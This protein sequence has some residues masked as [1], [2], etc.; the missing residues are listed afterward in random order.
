MNNVNISSPIKPY[1]PGLDSLRGLAII[2]V[3]GFHNFDFL[4]LFKYGWIGVDLFFVLSGFLITEILIKVKSTKNWLAKFYLKRILRIFPLYYVFLI[5]FYFLVNS[6][7]FNYSP[8]YFINHQA[9]FWSYM[10][11]WLFIIKYPDQY[12]ALNHFWSLA[13]EEQFYTI[14]PIIVLIVPSFKRLLKLTFLF[15]SILIF[16]RITVWLVHPLNISYQNFSTFTRADGLFIG[17]ALALL[18]KT[19]PTFIST[20]ALKILSS[21]LAVN[22][23]MLALKLLFKLNF[24]YL[25]L[26]GYPSIAI[27]CGLLVSANAKK[28]MNYASTTRKG[29]VFHFFAQISY[30]LY[31]FHWPVYILFFP[32]FSNLFSTFQIDSGLTNQLLAALCATF[33]AIATS[34]LTYY[35]LEKSFL[36]FKQKIN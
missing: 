14:W 23:L 25:S 7:T 3:I 20:H 5:I 35:S 10:Q 27:L 26:I 13:I 24:P 17:C 9:W 30:S 11:N 32:F 1:Y 12:T 22:I 2:L 4:Q 36:N 6:N 19:N 18:K 16:L 31:I 21:V 33:I 29:K 34:I 8:A 28:M 15:F